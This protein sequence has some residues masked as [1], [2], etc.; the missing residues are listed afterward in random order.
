MTRNASPNAIAVVLRRRAVTPTV[1]RIRASSGSMRLA[2]ALRVSPSWPL[3]ALESPHPTRANPF[4]LRQSP[5]F[6]RRNARQPGTDSALS[7]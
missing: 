3:E 1:P 5:T 6:H 4:E 7:P 2:S